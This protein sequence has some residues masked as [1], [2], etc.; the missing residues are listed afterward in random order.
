M[1]GWTG[2]ATQ[3]GASGQV[4]GGVQPS[5]TSRCTSPQHCGRGHRAWL[6]PMPALAG[7]FSRGGLAV[8]ATNSHASYFQTDMVA[9]RCERRLALCCYA[10]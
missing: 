8:E 2:G 5:G 9:I 1:M 10:Q 4:T 7:V 6:A 3:V